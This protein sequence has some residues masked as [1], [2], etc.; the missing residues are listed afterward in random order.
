MN[1][2]DNQAFLSLSTALAIGLLFGLERGRKGMQEKE[3]G[4]R[5]AGEC[6]FGLIGL[7]GGASGLLAQLLH[8]PVYAFVFVALAAVMAMNYAVNN[9]GPEDVGI[10]SLIAALLALS[11]G[12]LAALGHALTAGA[13][14]VIAVLLV[15]AVSRVADLNAITLSVPRMTQGEL[16]FLAATIAIVLAAATNGICVGDNLLSH[17]PMRL[18]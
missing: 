3:T 18:I 9:Q 12:A 16:P 5:V 4:A 13:A 8:S 10:T 17:S 6:A 2:T 14:A 7:L 15:A 1:L 11:L